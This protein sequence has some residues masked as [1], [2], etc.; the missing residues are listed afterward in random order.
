MDDMDDMDGPFSLKK[1]GS[2][3]G[4]VEESRTQCAARIAPRVGRAWSDVAE[5]MVI[6]DWA[7]TE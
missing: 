1:K 4:G 2:F 5:K 7:T 6:R 3:I